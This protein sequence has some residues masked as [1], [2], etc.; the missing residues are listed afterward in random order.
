MLE[1][2]A[3]RC[4]IRPRAE[5]HRWILEHAHSLGARD[6]AARQIVPPNNFSLNCYGLSGDSCE[7]AYEDNDTL[8]TEYDDSGSDE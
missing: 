1:N 3:G 4:F 6:F 8:Q 7:N 2:P 5:E